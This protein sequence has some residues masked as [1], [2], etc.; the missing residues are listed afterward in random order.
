LNDPKVLHLN[1]GE[2]IITQ[3]PAV[4][5]TVLGSCVC[6]CLY[7]IDKKACGM[8]HF[9]L[10]KKLG[11]T[12]GEDDLRYGEIAIPL[13]IEKF[14]EYV[15][16]NKANVKAKIVGGSNKDQQIRNAEVIAKENVLIARTLL[17]KYGI[18]IVNEDVGGEFGRQVLL[19]VP[20]GRVQC[21]ELNKKVRP[22]VKE[23]GPRKV[24]IVDD[25]KTIRN[26]LT[27]VLGESPDFEIV[28]AANDPFEAEEILKTVRPDVITL[29]VHMPKMTGVE[30]LPKLFAKQ[31]IPVVMIS[32][33]EL[34]DGNEVFKAL[35]LGAVDYIQKPDLKDMH[36]AT[37]IIR[38]KV[39]S[40]SY[41]KVMRSRTSS[42]R[43]FVS[44]DNVDLTKMIAIGASTGGT[45]ALKH[46]LC[47]FPSSIPPT[48]IV[49]H[50]PPVFSKAFADRLNELCPFE[51]KEAVDGDEVKRDRVLIAPGGTQMKLERMRSG[52]LVVRI[53]DDAPVNRHKP[54]VD[55]LFNSVATI[56]GKKAIGV[57]LTG[58]GADG[59]KGLLAMRNQGS[60]TIGQDEESCVVYGMP[61][62]AFEIG[63]VTE[64]FPLDQVASSI[65]RNLSK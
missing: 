5:S 21:A 52:Q 49:Q 22:I 26:I 34:Q 41:A 54:S 10:A 37:E 14:V 48:V 55:Y 51:V 7:T 42:F 39:K 50:I 60:Y 45:E 27:K 31:L 4:I 30:W 59:A 29:D 28:G 8:I 56:I 64:V 16:G 58:M 18:E 53:T 33:L 15:G 20:S 44:S 13:L 11:E 46:V 6:I 57:I 25:S 38:E 36:E 43:H 19:H 9:A 40:A 61:R 1:I 3:G 47:S 17:K 24:L 32:S 12:S 65:F 63:A 2:L 23:S 35:E 62:A